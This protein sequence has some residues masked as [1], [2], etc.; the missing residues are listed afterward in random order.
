MDALSFPLLK[1][2]G[3]GPRR[4]PGSKTHKSLGVPVELDLPGV[5]TSLAEPPAIWQIYWFS[6]PVIGF[7]SGFCS[8]S[9]APKSSDSLYLSLNL[10]VSGGSIALWPQ[11]SDG[12]KKMAPFSV[13]SVY[14]LLGAWAWQ[15]KLLPCWTETWKWPRKIHC[16]A[17]SVLGA[18]SLSFCL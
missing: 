12:A 1:I 3:W 13:C 18:E 4:A 16:P 6:Y 5:F 2:Q 14:F 9:S 7:S 15:L 8:W 17:H 11:F 10:F